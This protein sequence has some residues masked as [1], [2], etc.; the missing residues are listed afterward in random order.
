MLRF[1]ILSAALAMAG[2]A[3]PP[4]RVTHAAPS[5]APGEALPVHVG[6]RVERTTAGFRHQWP[7]IYF[8]SAFRGDRVTL[9]FDDPVNE[10]RV[11][12]DDKPP[13]SID[14]PGKAD[15]TIDGVGGG[16]HRIRLDKVTESAAPTIFG[17]FFVGT[18]NGLPAPR[19]H[20]RQIEFI[21]DSSMTGYGA[22][23]YRL[24]CT[25]EQVRATTDTPDAFAA[26]AAQQEGADYQINAISGRG[27]I[28]NAGGSAP[29]GA[30][31]QLWS[32]RIPAESSPFVDPA[33]QPQ[34][35]MLKLQADFVGLRPD[36]RWPNLAT[37]VADYAASYGRFLAQLHR[38]YPSAVFILW[39]FDT[40]GAPPDQSAMLREAELQISA[41]ARAAGVRDLLFLPFPASNFPATA[42]HGHYGVDEQ[43]RIADW[44]VAAIRAH[45][46]FWDGR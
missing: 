25:P 16:A 9:R 30:M 18:G 32:R 2:D 3:R 39:W 13:L 21:G 5:A 31:T 11:S 8:E 22:R 38:R 15:V 7:G 20:R 23:A 19:T 42:C 6:G 37:L 1:L 36:A 33:W 46:A 34:I 28:R 26:L 17:G 29:G 4:Q 10:W 14:R 27:L 41:T 43:R 24:D 35:V 12:V 44:L 40:Q 45:P